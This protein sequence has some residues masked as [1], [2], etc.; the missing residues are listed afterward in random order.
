LWEYRRKAI[1]AL[2]LKPGDTVVEIGCGTGLNFPLFQKFVGPAGEIIGV[3]LTDAMLEKDREQ[4]EKNSWKNVELVLCDAA[5]YEFPTGIGGIISTFAITLIPEFDKVIKNGCE[6][7][8]PGK[9][10]VVLDFKAPSNWL[11]SLTP[12][13]IFLLVHPFGGTIEAAARHPWESI[14]KYLKNTSFTKL[15]MGLIYIA[16][17]ECGENSSV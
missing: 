11:S 12:I 6:A 14:N 7:L 15:Y 2:N 13:L 5:K 16:T 8:S 10:W 17:G 9:R 4:V 3:D 1:E